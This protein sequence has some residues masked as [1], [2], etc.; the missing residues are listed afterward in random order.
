MEPLGLFGEENMCGTPW[1][2]TSR[3]FSNKEILSYLKIF[4]KIAK[5]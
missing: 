2:I 5:R 1:G 4:A 3:G